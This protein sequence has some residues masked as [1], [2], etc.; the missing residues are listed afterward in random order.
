MCGVRIHLEHRDLL[1]VIPAGMHIVDALYKLY[2]ND[3]KIEAN[4]ALIGSK[5]VPEK[6]KKG[7]PV[8][9]IMKEWQPKIEEFKKIR[10]KYLLYKPKKHFLLSLW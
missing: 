7:V 9:E 6:I 1:Q 8:E 4:F 3:Y 5:S 2:P 10:E